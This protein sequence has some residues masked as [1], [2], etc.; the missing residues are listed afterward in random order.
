MNMKRRSNTVGCAIDQGD[1][2]NEGGEPVETN[3]P[4]DI[5]NIDYNNYKGIYAEDDAGQKY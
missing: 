1:Y 4:D 5:D 3:D 2:M